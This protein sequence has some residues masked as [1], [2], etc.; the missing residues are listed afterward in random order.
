MSKLLVNI[1]TNKRDTLNMKYLIFC[2][3]MLMSC[4]QKKLL[5]IEQLKGIKEYQDIEIHEKVIDSQTNRTFINSFDK[6][7]VKVLNHL[8]N[9]SF[10]FYN[11]VNFR[12]SKTGVL[13]GGSGLRARLTQSG[14]STWKEFQFSKFANSFH[15]SAFLGENLWIVGESKYL[16]QTPDLGKTWNIYDT[17]KLIDKSGASLQP[18]YYK[19]KVV[20]SEMA[21]IVGSDGQ[22]AT[23]LSTHN[24]GK[25][26]SLLKL[27]PL[28]EKSIYVNDLHVFSPAHFI[29]VT[30]TGNVFETKDAAKT[31]NLLFKAPTSLNSVYF[32]NTKTGLIGGITG[33]LYFTNNAGK[34]WKQVELPFQSK[35]I[36]FSDISFHEDKFIVTSSYSNQLY[37]KDAPHIRKSFENVFTFQISKTGIYIDGFMQADL[38]KEPYLKDSYDIDISNDGKIYILDRA[39]LYKLNNKN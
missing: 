38:N 8:K 30:Y 36:N 3:L 12:D 14:G 31:W 7:S 33:G 18:K 2:A 19:I 15:S 6:R 13:V 28:L 17:S 39:N 9:T 20:T 4:N 11:D 10:H 35:K 23:I 29:V 22:R 34:T 1:S 5:E 37:F 16:F 32:K 27:N 25:K 21:L 24:T 26:W